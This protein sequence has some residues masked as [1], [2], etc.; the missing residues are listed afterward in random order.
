VLRLLAFGSQEFGNCQTDKV[1]QVIFSEGSVYHY[2]KGNALASIYC[3]TTSQTSTP[4]CLG[5]TPIR[6]RMPRKQYP[7]ITS[8]DRVRVQ[9]MMSVGVKSP[10]VTASLR[11]LPGLGP[12]L[13]SPFFLGGILCVC[14][15][16]IT[17]GASGK[18]ATRPS[19]TS[20]DRVRVQ[21]MMSV[22]VKSPTVTASLRMLPALA[23]TFLLRWHFVCVWARDNFWSF[24]QKSDPH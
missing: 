23:I 8:M 7:S 14:G 18:R 10:T 1:S 21:D 13:P 17:F 24:R 20:M 12:P 2:N 6:A 11:M 22:G 3:V 16:E 19:I 5:N 9:D 15:R 4:S